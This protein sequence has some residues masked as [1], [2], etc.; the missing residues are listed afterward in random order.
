M[1][2]RDF[3]KAAA[4]FF[5]PAEFV[6]LLDIDTSELIAA[7]EDAGYLD[8]EDAIGEIEE[9]MGVSDDDD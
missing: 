3:K 8:D 2:Y 6:E 5:T 7:L 9:I 4:D 1:N